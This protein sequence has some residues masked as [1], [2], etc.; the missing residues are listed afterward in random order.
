MSAVVSRISNML[1]IVGSGVILLCAIVAVVNALMRGAIGASIYG[2]NDI[3]ALMI[4]VGITA[5]M[6]KAIHGGEH[7]Q[8]TMLGNLLGVRL[9][10]IVESFAAILT[11]IFFGGLAYKA[12]GQ[13]MKLGRYNEVSEIAAVPLA[14]FWWTGSA[15]LIAA[16]LVQFWVLCD[17]WRRVRQ[18]PK[19]ESPT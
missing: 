4:F 3:L 15:M 2:V 11:L 7:M 16:A 1:A 17:T 9:R 19:H 8:V 6:P 18:D 5:C 10:I 13:A 12:V 14:P